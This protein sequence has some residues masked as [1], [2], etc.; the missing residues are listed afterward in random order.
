MASFSVFGM[1]IWPWS[2]ATAWALTRNDQFV[3]GCLRSGY[4]EGEL[5]RPSLG[6]IQ[7]EAYDWRWN[8]GIVQYRET[9]CFGRRPLMLFPTVATAANRVRLELDQHRWDFPKDDVLARFP[10]LAI[11]D[12]LSPLLWASVWRGS[13]PRSQE[14][15][16]FSHAAWWIASEQGTRVFA[17]DDRDS[18]RP[19]FDALLTVIED[20]EVALF[21]V[22][23]R[24]AR[25]LPADLLGSFDVNYPAMAL[26]QF[27]GSPYR[28][29]DSS[30]IETDLLNSEGDQ[31]FLQ[32]QR[33]PAGRGLQVSSTDL[34]KM[35]AE[36]RAGF[37]GSPA[38]GDPFGSELDQVAAKMLEGAS[39]VDSS[40]G[41]RPNN[42]VLYIPEACARLK[43]GQVPTKKTPFARE[44]HSW[45]E[46]IPKK[47]LKGGIE[48]ADTIARHIGP[49]WEVWEAHRSPKA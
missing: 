23:S 11:G 44:I 5:C 21:T 34:L 4:G 36:R 46:T 8:T 13:D 22:D 16:T 12:R 47:D 43:T 49:L 20:G 38:S 9:M 28:P 25:R 45:L 39:R 31:Y 42:L 15:V 1:Q 6:A 3:E 33:E 10:K 41:G 26:N 29:G 35:F 32:G 2:I 30:F 24:R 40:K 17:L 37:A 18:W 19:A 14:R 7:T 48:D 27:A